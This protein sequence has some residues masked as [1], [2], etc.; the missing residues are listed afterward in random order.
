MT[1]GLAFVSIESAQQY[2]DCRLT[3]RNRGVQNVNQQPHSAVPVWYWVIAVVALLWNLLG[4]LFFAVEMFALEAAMQGWTEP[5]KEWARSIPGW[6]YGVYGL[7]VT[8]GVAGSIG[9]LLRKRWTITL[10]RVCLAAVIVQMGYTM[11]VLGGFRV[12]GPSDAAMPVLV[13]AIAAGL[14]WFSWFARGRG[15]IG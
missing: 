10:F 6:I 5:Q 3:S 12:M 1:L 7:A 15:W 2:D 4:C 8:T 14:L 9:L 13:I 11:L